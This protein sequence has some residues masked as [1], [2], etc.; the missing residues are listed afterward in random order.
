ML[1]RASQ[2]LVIIAAKSEL[3]YYDIAK[4]KI[5]KSFSLKSDVTCFAPNQAEEKFLKMLFTLMPEYKYESCYIQ[6][7]I[8]DGGGVVADVF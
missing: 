1:C 2:N 4:K 5:R 8:Y 6:G 7:R 3:H